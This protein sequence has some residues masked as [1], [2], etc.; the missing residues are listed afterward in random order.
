MSNHA[1]YSFRTCPFLNVLEE[2]FGS[3]FVFGSL[4]KDFERFKSLLD[5]F[6]RGS[7]IG[8]AKSTRPHSVLETTA[9]NRFNRTKTI[10]RRGADTY[11]L[12]APQIEVPGL[13]SWA[14]GSDSFCNWAMYKVCKYISDRQLSL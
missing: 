9:L 10:D 11:P 8:F 4:N 12:H 1:I 14:T 3:V 2:R 5:D 13:R 7:I 6:P